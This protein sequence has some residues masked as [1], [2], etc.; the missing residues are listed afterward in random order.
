MNSL[1]H[2]CS[3]PCT[4]ARAFRTNLR[5]SFCAAVVF[6]CIYLHFQNYFSSKELSDWQSSHES[7]K[8]WSTDLHA[9]PVGCQID[10]MNSINVDVVAK[11]DFA[12]CGF[13]TN[14]EGQDICAKTH[15]L[16]VFQQDGWKGF[17]LDPSPALLRRKFYDAY[18]NDKEFGQVDYV[19]CSHPAANCELYLAFNKSMVV[20]STTRV[21][22]GRND[23]YVWWRQPYLGNRTA[24]WNHWLSN[25]KQLYN[26]P[27]H[28]VAANNRYDVNHMLYHTGVRA[29]Y[30]PSWCGGA[31]SAVTDGTYDPQR[32]EL[33]LTPYRLNL[34]YA[35]E[36]VPEH[37]WPLDREKMIDSNEHP[38]FDKLRAI[39]S[40]DFNLISMSDAFPSGFETISEFGA[41]RAAVVIPYQA[42]TMFF[43]E[44]Y[45]SAT[46]IIAPSLNLLLDWVKKYRILWE[47]SYGNPPRSTETQDFDKFPN[48]NAFD[49]ESRK[50][51]LQFFDIY[52]KD[53]FP[54]ILYFNSWSHAVEMVKNTDLRKVSEKMREHN[55]LEYHRIQGWWRR[56]LDT[57][58]KARRANPSSI[59]SLDYDTELARNG[60]DSLSDVE[61]QLHGD[62][63][64]IA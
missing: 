60:F 11:I 44:L 58:D 47:V 51:W 54:H 43:F 46:P 22:F 16:K 7:R 52:Q 27:L 42:S 36:S 10:I 14:S 19:M 57:L 39:Q 30:I 13:F 4:K 32:S 3:T 34:E 48:P 53:V 45:R 1:P 37:G 12:N 40:D 63:P 50:H 31:L 8:L 21:E 64:R 2:C 6:V 20:Y 15:G 59:S 24:R 23:E 55:V 33:V 9:A 18:K 28:L 35:P 41:F 38:V 25:L 5:S 49:A 56:E 17:S 26:S 61:R 62:A 29:K